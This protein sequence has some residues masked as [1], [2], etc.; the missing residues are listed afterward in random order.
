MQWS[1][2]CSRPQDRQKI[3]EMLAKEQQENLTVDSDDG[4]HGIQIS[5]IA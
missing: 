5:A 1:K 3:L 2:S 4:M